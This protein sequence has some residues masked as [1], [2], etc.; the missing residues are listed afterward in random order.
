[1]EGH[2]RNP[3]RKMTSNLAR[4][5]KA[6]KT[7]RNSGK[8]STSERENLENMY[9]SGPAAYGSA[10]NLLKTS[11]MSKAKVE[12]LLQ[13][14]DAHTKYRQIQRTFHRPKVIAYKIKETRSIDVAYVDK[15]AK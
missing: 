15:L 9:T 11:K 14:K 3:T 5:L 1:M 13:Q 4:V 6:K 12:T 2:Q 7:G 8:Y 10:R